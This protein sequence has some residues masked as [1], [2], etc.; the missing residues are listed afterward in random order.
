MKR[1]V[2]DCLDPYIIPDLLGIIDS[3]IYELPET[4]IFAHIHYI[5][6]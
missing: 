1:K 3:Y 5:R 2:Q 4:N 6:N